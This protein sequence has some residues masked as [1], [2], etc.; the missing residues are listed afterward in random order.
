MKNIFVGGELRSA[1]QKKAQKL[2]KSPLL[3][4]VGVVIFFILLS[5]ILANTIKHK[6]QFDSVALVEVDGGSGSA[7]HIGNNK[8]LT[9][10]HVVYGMQNGD[11]CQVIFEDPNNTSGRKIHAL[12]Q[13][14]AM[15][16]WNPLDTTCYTNDFALLVVQTVDLSDLGVK[17]A[18]IGKSANIK[19]ND[20]INVVGYP[21]GVYMNT[22][23]TLNNISGGILNN[24]AMV[25]VNAG[26]WPG[27]SGG[28]LFNSNGELIGIVTLTGNKMSN[29][30]SGQT[31]AIK[32]DHI[33]SELLLKGHKI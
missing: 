27:N 30:T 13:L 4:L 6:G 25:V 28:G 24:T 9:A 5:V 11:A 21:N 10:A 31:M 33:R 26:A 12:A 32:T 16:N 8:L 20:N 2:I 19:V 15:G 23:G 7:I 14:S 22:S 1:R 17:V 18:P 3:A 29:E